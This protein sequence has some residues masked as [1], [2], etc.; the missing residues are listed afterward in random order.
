MN[1]KKT[2]RVVIIYSKKEVTQKE[3]KHALEIL[4]CD[5]S[6]LWDYADRCAIEIFEIPI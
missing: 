4:N 3:A 5:E 2:K 1:E 6:L